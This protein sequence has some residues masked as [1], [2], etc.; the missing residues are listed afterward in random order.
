MTNEQT[1][2]ENNKG[3]TSHIFERLSTHCATE[4]SGQASFRAELETVVAATIHSRQRHQEGG[5][6]QL[7][8]HPR[9]RKHRD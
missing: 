2:P 6:R 7:F 9:Q 3:T 8:P 5:D 4:E 1:D